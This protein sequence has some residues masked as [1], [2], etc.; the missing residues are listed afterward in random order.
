MGLDGCG[1]GG[2]HAGPRW[3]DALRIFRV[4]LGGLRGAGR[5][6]MV[7]PSAAPCLIASGRA[8]GLADF[9]AAGDL[10]SGRVWDKPDPGDV[11]CP[12]MEGR[13]AEG[14]GRGPASVEACGT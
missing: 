12:I 10:P 9:G 13:C 7:G 14:D 5:G 1:K 8:D 4:G 11:F 6:E 2:A 3:P